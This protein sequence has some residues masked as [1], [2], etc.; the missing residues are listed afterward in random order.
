MTFLIVT[1][2]WEYVSPCLRP[3]RAHRCSFCP[4]VSLLFTS[5]LPF[6]II[7]IPPFPIKLLPHPFSHL[8]PLCSWPSPSPSSCSPPTFHPFISL[9]YSLSAVSHLAC[10]CWAAPDSVTGQRGSP[11][12]GLPACR[13]WRS[14][15]RRAERRWSR[16]RSPPQPSSPTRATI[17]GP[18]AHGG[19][20]TRRYTRDACFVVHESDRGAEEKLSLSQPEWTQSVS[21]ELKRVTQKVTCTNSINPL[22]PLILYWAVEWTHKSD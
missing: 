15:G 9:V 17:A 12:R 21:V 7:S 3:S 2:L 5:S 18:G 6:P 16:H 4:S 8:L 19:T 22:P 14:G 13:G 11:P 1:P 10:W 20:S